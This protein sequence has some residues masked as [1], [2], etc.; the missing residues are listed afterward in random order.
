MT[1]SSEGRKDKET[2]TPKGFSVALPMALSLPI[3]D[4]CSA[5]GLAGLAMTSTGGRL[6][7]IYEMS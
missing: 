3:T 2:D 7:G 1:Q 6:G 4:S 5:P